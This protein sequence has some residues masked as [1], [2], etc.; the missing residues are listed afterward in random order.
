[1]HG[2]APALM[3]RDLLS[4]AAFIRQP[5]DGYLAPL[6]A[7]PPESLPGFRPGLLLGGPRASCSP[8]PCLNAPSPVELFSVWLSQ[9]VS[10]AAITATPTDAGSLFM[11]NRLVTIEYLM[12]QGINR[13]IVCVCTNG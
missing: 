11:K 1:M 7:T 6:G 12:N 2:N 13:A 8:L 4:F 9:P 3:P 10:A 5:S